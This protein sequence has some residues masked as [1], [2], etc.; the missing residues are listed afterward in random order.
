MKDIE[1]IFSEGLRN[2]PVAPPTAHWSAL[3]GQLRQRRRRRILYRVAAVAL[4]LTG[5]S[6]GMLLWPTTS[7]SPVANKSAAIPTLERATWATHKIAP[8]SA[9]AFLG[10]V[11]VQNASPEAVPVEVRQ[12]L[13]EHPAEV[14]ERTIA[15]PP[16]ESAKE[17]PPTAQ[18]T[19]LVVKADRYRRSE[20]PNDKP[21]VSIT[22]TYRPN[23]AAL[24]AKESLGQKVTQA[25]AK[26][27]E[28]RIGLSG[29][30]SA[31]NGLIEQVFSKKE[32]STTSRE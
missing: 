20:V 9:P 28:Q 21:P 16:L 32:P 11:S 3:S 6:L 27:K 2:H 30:R 10:L 15:V 26:I 13:T 22:V 18:A 25:L 8:M 29:I 23:P 7:V 4:L 31:K 1:K 5:V 17:L 19:T 24:A 12:S 14:V